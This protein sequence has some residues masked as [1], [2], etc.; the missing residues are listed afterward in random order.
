MFVIVQ[1][2]GH[3]VVPAGSHRAVQGVQPSHAF[4]EQEIPAF[5]NRLLCGWFK[6]TFKHTQLPTQNRVESF[7]TQNILAMSVNYLP[8]TEVYPPSPCSTA[9]QHA[10]R[11]PSDADELNNVMQARIGN[12]TAEALHFQLILALT[13][14]SP[15]ESLDSAIQALFGTRASRTHTT[16]P[17]SK[18]LNPTLPLF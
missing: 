2:S 10:A 7:F 5:L 12:C 11:D 3:P 18:S 13:R 6:I 15:R 14:V 17:A 4:H 1:R 8:I 16:T 9:D